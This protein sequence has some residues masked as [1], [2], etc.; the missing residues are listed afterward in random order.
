MLFVET[1]PD[2]Q[3]ESQETAY[4]ISAEIA[5]YDMKASRIYNFISRKFHENHDI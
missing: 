5:L 3:K 4:A 1:F 2:F